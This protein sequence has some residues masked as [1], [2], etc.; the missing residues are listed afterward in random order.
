MALSLACTEPASSASRE[1]ISKDTLLNFQRKKEK[2]SFV[3]V[4]H[5]S[6]LDVRLPNTKTETVSINNDFF[7]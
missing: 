7:F 3:F 5:R 2:S 4:T 1:Q 6:F